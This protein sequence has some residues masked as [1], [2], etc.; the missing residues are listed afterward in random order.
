MTI[1]YDSWKNG[2]KMTVFEVIQKRLSIRKY[3]E[4]PIPED[5]LESEGDIWRIV[6]GV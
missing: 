1:L 4:D 6:K 5:V 2:G 3:K